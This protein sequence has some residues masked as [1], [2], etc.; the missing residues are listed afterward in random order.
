MMPPDVSKSVNLAVKMITPMRMKTAATNPDITA[1][2]L[3]ILC[4]DSDDINIESAVNTEAT[5]TAS[6]PKI[7]KALTPFS[8]PGAL[9]MSPHMERAQDFHIPKLRLNVW[10]WIVSETDIQYGLANPI[11]SNKHDNGNRNKAIFWTSFAS[12]N[13]IFKN[14][15]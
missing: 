1:I 15:F 14:E 5:I 12:E 11:T 6:I 2:I 10:P 7:S 8:Q 3:P 13:P 9:V 4:I